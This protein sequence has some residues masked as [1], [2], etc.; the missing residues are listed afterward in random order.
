MPNCIH[1]II[2]YTCRHIYASPAPP[3]HQPLRLLPASPNARR[4]KPRGPRPHHNP[5]TKEPSPQ[6]KLERSSTFLNLAKC[7]AKAIPQHAADSAACPASTIDTSLAGTH[8]STLAPFR[9][10]THLTGYGPLGPPAPP[11]LCAVRAQVGVA[12]P[13]STRRRFECTSGSAASMG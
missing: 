6:A 13:S 3:P 2:I 5:A 4:R 7:L 1:Y 10:Q 9:R 11:P 12:Q 8:G